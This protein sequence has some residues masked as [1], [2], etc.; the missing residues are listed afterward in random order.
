MIAAFWS[1]SADPRLQRADASCGKFARGLAKPPLAK[2]ELR[3]VEMVVIFRRMRFSPV[4]LLWNGWCNSHLP[5][6]EA[7]LS[8]PSKRLVERALGTVRF[9]ERCATARG[10]GAALATSP[11]RSLLRSAVAIALIVSWIPS[12]I[13]SS[14][15]PAR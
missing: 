4:N 5:V 15:S 12:P 2:R 14:V 10:A 1:V 3:G 13:R 9:V 6:G 7:D 11:Y 8:H